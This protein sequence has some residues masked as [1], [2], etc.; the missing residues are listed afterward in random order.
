MPAPKPA[1]KPAEPRRA[2]RCRTCGE[3]IDVPDG[4]SHGPAVRRHY[5]ARHR[6]VMTRTS[7]KARS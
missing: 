5:W 3:D 1:S 6:D 4:W 2:P 7:R